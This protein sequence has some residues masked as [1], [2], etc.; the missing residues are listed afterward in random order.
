MAQETK[1]TR[2][3]PEERAAELRARAEELER[4]AAERKELAEKRGTKL[5]K[6]MRT[7]LLALDAALMEAYTQE[8]G[9]AQLHRRIDMARDALATAILEDYGVPLPMP[10]AKKGESQ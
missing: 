7:A 10:R 1:R 2:R 4:K 6:A 8:P 3:T 9:P 5:Y